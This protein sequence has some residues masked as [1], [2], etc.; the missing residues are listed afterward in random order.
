[1]VFHPAWGYFADR[2]NLKELAVEVNG[3]SPK[4]REIIDI[5][6]RAKREKVKAIFTQPEFSDKSAKIIANNL[7]IDVIKASPLAT[8]WANNL[9]D[10]AEAIAKRE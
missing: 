8:D 2:Y 6:K 1:M 5:I 7:N 10:L 4:M 3:K 9:I